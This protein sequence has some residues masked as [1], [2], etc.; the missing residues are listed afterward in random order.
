MKKTRF[1]LVVKSALLIALAVC[2]LLVSTMHVFASPSTETDVST[3]AR[4]PGGTD[5]IAGAPLTIYDKLPVKDVN[6]GTAPPAASD[7]AA[8]FDPYTHIVVEDG[9]STVTI[10]SEE[11]LA[12]LADADWLTLTNEEAL[13]LLNDTMN[14]FA[15]YDEVRIFDEN[16]ELQTYRGASFY[17]SEEYYNSFGLVS[18][19][20]DVTYNLKQDV[21]NVMM[22]RLLVLCSA[23]ERFNISGNGNEAFVFLGREETKNI[24]LSGEMHGIHFYYSNPDR[25]ILPET[26]DGEWCGH[27]DADTIRCEFCTEDGPSEFCHH[28]VNNYSSWLHC[29]ESL[30]NANYGVLWFE[31]GK[32]NYV[33]DLSNADYHDKIR[34]YPDQLFDD[35]VG[36]V[37]YDANGEKV[38]IIEVWDTASESVIARIRLDNIQNP[39]EIAQL[40]ALWLPVKENCDGAPSEDYFTMTD[41]RVAVYL[42]GFE[43]KWGNYAFRYAPDG[44]LDQW[45]FQNENDIFMPLFLTGTAEVAA[46]VN[47]LLINALEK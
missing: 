11:Q 13:Y 46:Y 22:T 40:E 37:K 26:V 3:D 47:E 31:Q 10:Y 23:A 6:D 21:Y 2:T 28:S 30:M 35:T 25:F 4:T 7:Y 29:R 45:A 9:R 32:I 14:L 12:A 36:N 38:A 1:P 33:E 8:R 24:F 15:N 20:D 43:G 18:G 34:L 41:Y 5:T 42:N 44:N 39:E 27:C 19:E 16:G 17:T